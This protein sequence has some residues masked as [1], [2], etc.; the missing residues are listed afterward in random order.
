MSPRTIQRLVKFE[1]CDY[2][3]VLRLAKRKR[4]GGSDFSVALHTIIK[5]WESCQAESHP[6]PG[7][8]EIP[9]I[10]RLSRGLIPSNSSDPA[11]SPDRKPAEDALISPSTSN[12]T[13]YSSSRLA[14]FTASKLPPL[15]GPGQPGF[16]HPPFP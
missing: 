5:E 14:G 9:D 3:L 4:L 8:A 7:S 13:P 11:S 12:E 10:A 16:V 1:P 15:P 2:R 6:A